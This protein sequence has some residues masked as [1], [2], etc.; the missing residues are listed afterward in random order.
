MSDISFKK[1]SLFIDGPETSDEQITEIFGLFKNN[2]KL[3][4]LKKERERLKAKRAGVTGN[5]EDALDIA[6][7]NLAAGK[8][9]GVILDKDLQA[10]LGSNDR[11]FLA[12]DDA[13]RDKEADRIRKKL[14]IKEG[15]EH[16][17]VTEPG[18]YVVDH[19][20][21]P[22]EGP[23][24]KG[25]AF[26]RADELSAEHAGDGDISAYDVLYFDEDDIKSMKK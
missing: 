10:A 21:K 9:P 11:K 24:Q 16:F 6:L 12:K 8:K 15:A 18:H 25:A 13:W 17:K 7:K 14:G 4:K 1:F 5:K 20:D 22:V 3:E 23:M 26:E 2:D 19:M